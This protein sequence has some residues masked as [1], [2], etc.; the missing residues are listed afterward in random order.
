MYTIVRV[1]DTRVSTA[2]NIVHARLDPQT[3]QALDR[4]RRKTGLTESE[5]IRRSLLVLDR[6]ESAPRGRR[7]VG[8]GEFESGKDDLGSDERH[9]AGFGRS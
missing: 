8:V 6:I 5:I 2:R 7:I 3:R 4:L 1:Y 9:L